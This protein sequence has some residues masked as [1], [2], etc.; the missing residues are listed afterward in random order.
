MTAWFHY[1]AAHTFTAGNLNGLIVLVMIAIPALIA[2][3]VEASFPETRVRMAGYMAIGLLVIGAL[4]FELQTSGWSDGLGIMLM[5]T[6]FLAI[7]IFAGWSI[8]C[9]WAERGREKPRAQEQ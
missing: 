5:V 7:P 9:S 8:G 2:A 4:F 6:P 1:L 3:P